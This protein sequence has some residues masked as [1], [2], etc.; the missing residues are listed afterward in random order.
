M[1]DTTD[2][3]PKKARKR[4]SKKETETSTKKAKIN[5]S[6]EE[7]IECDIKRQNNDSDK[8][9]MKDVVCDDQQD[10]FNGQ[11]FRTL[12][13]SSNNLA[14]LR[15]FV[16]IC[17]ENKER[18]LAAEYLHA[19]GSV[20]EILRLLE[21]SDKKS[22][23]IATTVFSTTYILLMRYTSSRDNIHGNLYI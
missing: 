10:I 9:D 13:S 18:N 12:F 19:G 8:N 23:S 3:K 17:K 14:A 15:K 4:T 1:D 16:T 11:S 2:D 6:I 5:S 20:F 22:T 21:S 7:V